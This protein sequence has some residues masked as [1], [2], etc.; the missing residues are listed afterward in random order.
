MLASSDL[1]LRQNS[2]SMQRPAQR[3][4]IP[5]WINRLLG[6]RPTP[7]IQ[8]ETPNSTPLPTVQGVTTASAFRAHP[9]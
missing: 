1:P 9:R 8:L 6:V 2:V 3:V 4:Q 5:S 7:E